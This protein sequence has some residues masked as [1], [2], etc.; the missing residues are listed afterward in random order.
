MLFRKGKMQAKVNQ[1]TKK[2]QYCIYLY[3]MLLTI[4]IFVS[5]SD[6]EL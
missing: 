6:A 2:I 5:F 3:K 1:S 4:N